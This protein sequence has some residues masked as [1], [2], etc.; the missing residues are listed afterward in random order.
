LGIGWP[1][2]KLDPAQ[3]AE[4]AARVVKELAASS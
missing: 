3:G 1:A 2:G 4:L